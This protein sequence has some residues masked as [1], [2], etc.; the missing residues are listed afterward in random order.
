MKRPLYLSI[1]LMATSPLWAQGTFVSPAVFATAEGNAH[2]YLLGGYANAHFQ[3]GDGELRGTKRAIDD[4][5]FRLDHVSH[6]SDTAMGRKWTLVSVIVAETDWTKFTNLFTANQLTTPVEVFNGA[7]AWPTVQGTPSTKPAL[8][9]GTYAFPFKNPWNYSGV[10]D[11]VMD[12]FFHGGT[13]D[14]SAAWSGST[15]YNYNLDSD[16]APV[17]YKSPAPF[18]PTSGLNPP[19]R[20]S[21]ISLG[22]NAQTYASLSVHG[23]FHANVTFRNKAEFQLFS[24]Y[25]APNSQLITAIAFG[26]NANGV[27]IGA[28]C[29]RLYPNLQ[30]PWVA[31]AWT[32]DA[33]A[34]SGLYSALVT[35]KPSMANTQIW[36]Q[37]AWNDSVLKSFSLTQAME[38]T[39]PLAEPKIWQRIGQFTPD[40]TAKTGD[41]P[42]LDWYRGH[43]ITRY[44]HN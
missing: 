29:N 35:W 20:D 44:T 21:A 34:Y 40:V 15:S 6:T 8:F 30:I 38:V 23:S 28:R 25:T 18:Y 27:N 22:A 24:F 16:A 43:P 33:N 3:L 9:G 31:K 39:L 7:V 5:R 11:F 19:C 37:S 41:G 12:I 17:S 1:F 36:V 32:T 26:G 42:H 14:N 4:I 10:L 2:A 13:M